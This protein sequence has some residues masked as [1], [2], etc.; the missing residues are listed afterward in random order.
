MAYGIFRL[1]YGIFRLTYCYL[2]ME[3][4]LFHMECDDKRSVVTIL[5]QDKI[6]SAKLALPVGILD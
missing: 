1:T 6:W 4:D 2:H 3:C 5:K